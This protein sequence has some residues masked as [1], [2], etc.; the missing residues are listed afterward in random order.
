MHYTHEVR[1]HEAAS[2]S[3]IHWQSVSASVSR[4]LSE[5]ALQSDLRESFGSICPD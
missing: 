4:G 5:E 1:V 3:G 2:P